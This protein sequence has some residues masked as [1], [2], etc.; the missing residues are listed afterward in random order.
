MAFPVLDHP[1]TCSRNSHFCRGPP[2]RLDR[3]AHTVLDEKCSEHGERSYGVPHQPFILGPPSGM[4]RE[5]IRL[6]P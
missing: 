6:E 1:G 3:V 5:E 2:R 4:Y